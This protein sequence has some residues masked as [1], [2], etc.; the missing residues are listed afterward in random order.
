MAIKRDPVSGGIGDGALPRIDTLAINLVDDGLSA[1]TSSRPLI[2]VRGWRI[3]IGPLRRREQLV[4][5]DHTI[6]RGVL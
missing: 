1:S 4:V 6:T 3:V 5:K 2:R